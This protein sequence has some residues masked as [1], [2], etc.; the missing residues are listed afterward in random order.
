MRAL[1]LFATAF[2]LAAPAFAQQKASFIDG[3]YTFA[4]GA[5]DKLK[6]LAAGGAQSVSTVPWYVTADGISFWEGGCSFSKISKGKKKDE[7][8]VVAA[9]SEN[10]EEYTESYTFRRTSP[11]GFAV[12][13]T[14]PGTAAKDAKP[15]QYERCDVGK[16][17]DPR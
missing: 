1:I 8:K 12:T 5:C 2:A 14:S 16:I 6:A 4:P 9:C 17:P 10:D 3:T 11:T 15:V 7:W 13:L